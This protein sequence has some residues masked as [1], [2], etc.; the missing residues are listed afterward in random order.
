ML[1]LSKDR[2]IFIFE[3]KQCQKNNC[4]TLKMISL[5]S[6]ETSIAIYQSKRLAKQKFLFILAAAALLLLSKLSMEGKVKNR[7]VQWSESSVKGPC[8]VWWAARH[9]TGLSARGQAVQLSLLCQFAMSLSARGSFKLPQLMFGFYNR[10]SR[11]CSVPQ[12]NGRGPLCNSACRRKNGFQPKR[13][14]NEA[15]YSV[16]S[17]ASC[18]TGSE[19]AK[20]TP[21]MLLVSLSPVTAFNVSFYASYLNMCS[22]CFLSSR[23]HASQRKKHGIHCRSN[24]CL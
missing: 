12:I 16:R 3:V 7:R 21:R 6:S 5:R 24:F 15:S 13:T 23:R 1:N 22:N 19:P 17:K 20:S 4:L 8:C 18:A 14:H 11:R 2:Y 9:F 10:I